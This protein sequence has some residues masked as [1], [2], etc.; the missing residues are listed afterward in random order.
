MKKYALIFIP[1]VI[2]SCSISKRTESSRG[3]LVKVSHFSI[4][5]EDR[6]TIF[7]K[8]GTGMGESLYNSWESGLFSKENPETTALLVSSDEFEI[9]SSKASEINNTIAKR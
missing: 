4:I 8:I 1:L 6:D 2:A 5:T 7:L 3:N 9:L